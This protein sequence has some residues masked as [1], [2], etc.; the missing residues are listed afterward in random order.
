MSE[1]SKATN[2]IVIIRA[3]IQKQM[4]TRPGFRAMKSPVSK[5]GSE[6]LPIGFISGSGGGPFHNKK[7]TFE[8][9]RR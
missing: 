5:G 9:E 1:K 4:K 7:Q 6:G 3:D 8:N 2:P